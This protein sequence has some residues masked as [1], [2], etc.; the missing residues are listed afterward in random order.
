MTEGEVKKI[1]A[2]LDLMILKESGPQR[3]ANPKLFL[4]V[5][6]RIARVLQYNYLEDF[7]KD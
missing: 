5:I 4:G 6:T 3:F 1:K 2:N 7:T